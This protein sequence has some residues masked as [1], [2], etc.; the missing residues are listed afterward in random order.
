MVYLTEYWNQDDEDD[1]S[2]IEER[3]PMDTEDE[4]TYEDEE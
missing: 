4:D 1:L 3:T 2:F